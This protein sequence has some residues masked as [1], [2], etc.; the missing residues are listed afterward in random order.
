MQID[1]GEANLN[2][3]YN[4]LAQ[5]Q[6]LYSQAQRQL[7]SDYGAWQRAQSSENAGATYSSIQGYLATQEQ[8]YKDGLIGTDE[9]KTYTALFDQ[10]GR[11][12]LKAYTENREKM[13]RYLTEDASGVANVLTD[14]VSNGFGTYDEETM[15]YDLDL[16]NLNK[17]ASSI[18]VSEEFL[19]YALQRTEDYGFTT[20]YVRDQIQ[21]ELKLSDL[22]QQTGEAIKKRN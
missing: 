7:F 5:Y 14:L 19:D 16:P 1:A 22:V 10:W 2:N 21:G 20:D 9:F 11:D 12:T 17:A 6:A 8:A 15:R 3:M 13:Q 4:Q 18:G